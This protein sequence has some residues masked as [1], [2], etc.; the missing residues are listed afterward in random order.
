MGSEG[1]VLWLR[2]HVEATTLHTQQRKGIIGRVVRCC[3]KTCWMEGGG[4][5]TECCGAGVRVV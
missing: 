2:L 1:R 3:A 4:R 5:G